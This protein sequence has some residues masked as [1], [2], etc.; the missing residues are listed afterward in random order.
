M[1]NDTITWGETYDISVTVKDADGNAIVL[2]ETYSAACRIVTK[3]HGGPL[4]AE[5]P[6]TI[7]GGAATA[8]IDTGD[9][10]WK[11]GVYFYDVRITD[12]AGNDF[13][14]EYVR[15]TLNVRNTPNT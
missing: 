2:D 7:A 12:P 1:K 15:L 4:F 8:S 5:P 11:A 13:W 10:P 3:N 14:S 9:R 6:M